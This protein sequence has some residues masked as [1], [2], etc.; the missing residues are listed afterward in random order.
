MLNFY[1]NRATFQNSASMGFLSLS[2]LTKQGR[3]L[4]CRRPV[5]QHVPGVRT[6]PF[7]LFNSSSAGK[8][9]AND[10]PY[11][12]IEGRSVP[13]GCS[14][15]DIKM[16][17]GEHRPC[18]LSQRKPLEFH[19]SSLLLCPWAARMFNSYTNTLLWAE[20]KL[21]LKPRKDKQD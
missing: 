15:S 12:L 21:S 19:F 13:F 17:E 18:K 5:N 3:I 6:T 4:T 8:S 16:S 1:S 7:I 9:V 11:Y 2:R 20:T 10:P 14:A